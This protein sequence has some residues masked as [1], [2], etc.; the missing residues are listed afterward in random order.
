MT[1]ATLIAI[2]A[3]GAALSGGLVTGFATRGVEKLR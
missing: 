3:A 1:E 2:I